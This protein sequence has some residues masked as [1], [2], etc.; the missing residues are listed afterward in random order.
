M[1]T[2]RWAERARAQT[3]LLHGRVTVGVRRRTR[4][5]V[6]IASY[7]MGVDDHLKHCVVDA[8]RLGGSEAD[9]KLDE[10][11]QAIARL[12]RS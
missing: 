11:S 8:A 6:M 5:S 12:V 9:A 2:G 3:R 10:A 4:G 7:S 1:T